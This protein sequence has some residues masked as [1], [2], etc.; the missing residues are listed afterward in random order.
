MPPDSAWSA[1]LRIPGQ[2]PAPGAVRLGH[3]EHDA[4][5]HALIVA[6]VAV[7]R[8]WVAR[9][10]RE[11]SSASTAGR[12]GEDRGLTASPTMAGDAKRPPGEP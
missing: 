3:G 12:E 7:A 2:A 8:R 9:M 6:V 1:S 10:G 11:A 5:L 4:D